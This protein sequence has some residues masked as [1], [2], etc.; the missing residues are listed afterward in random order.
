MLNDVDISVIIPVYNAEKFIL[1]AVESVLSQECVNIELIII[2]DG[3]TDTS[4]EIIQSIND[5]RIKYFKKENGG[6]VSALNFAIS[7]TH[8]NLIARM[9]ADDI[10]EPLRL[11]KQLDYMIRNDLD[12]VGGNIKL[13]DENDQVIGKKNF[14]IN[15]FDII[16]SMPFINPLC[17]PATII[18]ATVLKE[19]N[20]YTLGTDG[21][22]DFDLWCRL[23]G[24]YKFG[25]LP[26]YVLSYRLTANSISQSSH[27][28][29]IS[30]CTESI[31]DNIP[32]AP[33]VFYSFP[34]YFKRLPDVFRYVIKYSCVTNFRSFYYMTSGFIRALNFSFKI[35]KEKK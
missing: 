24:I 19:V 13:I 23:S 16:S 9:D 6:I 27:L 17:H 21:A 34:S 26:E 29:R 14:P 15:H 11:K 35:Y 32:N 1:T 25:N 10:M 3:S 8:S 30:L 31:R 20:G 2:D 7:K 28:H 4:G 12:I 33:I 5:N 22:E 18:K